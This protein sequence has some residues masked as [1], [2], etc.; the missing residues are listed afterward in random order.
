MEITTDSGAFGVLAHLE[1]APRP[2]LRAFTHTHTRTHTRTHARARMLCYAIGRHQGHVSAE[3]DDIYTVDD[4]EALAVGS[5]T[6][7][8]SWVDA[9]RY[10]PRRHMA[11][12]PLAVEAAV[13]EVCQTGGGIL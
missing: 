3:M 13:A 2:F 6:R 12:V 7:V 10:D 1:D 8:L 5:Q 11:A 4:M 9:A